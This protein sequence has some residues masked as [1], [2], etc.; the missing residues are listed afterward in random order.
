MPEEL[1]RKLFLAVDAKAS[2]AWR[3]QAQPSGITD[4]NGVDSDITHGSSMPASILRWQPPKSVYEAWIRDQYNEDWDSCDTLILS[5]SSQV[6]EKMRTAWHPSHSAMHMWNKSILPNVLL[7]CL[8]DRT[9]MANSLEGRPPFLDHHLAEYVNS[10]PP[11]VKL[12]LGS[13]K[14]NRLGKNGSA[15][16]FDYLTEKWILRE[17]GRPYLTDELYNQRKVTFWAPN[18]WP[19][20]GRLHV[21]F[22]DLLTKEAISQLGFVDYNAVAQALDSAFGDVADDTS[23]RIICYV[24]SWVVLSQKV[25]IKQVKR[26]P[27]AH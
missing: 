14:A 7:A 19:R 2:A 15:S 17:A 23:F 1:R 10:L 12:K 18:R 8:G 24:A 16:A 5:H 11:S 27:K 3:S 13:P 9:E 25:G 6:R 26:G 22:M 20:G 4:D 21:M